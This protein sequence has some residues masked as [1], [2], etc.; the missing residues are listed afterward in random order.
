MRTV[1]EKAGFKTEMT[2]PE[3]SM[4]DALASAVKGTD[5]EEMSP[6]EAI[7]AALGRITSGAT[8]EDDSAERAILSQGRP[9]AR[10]FRFADPK[11][12]ADWADLRQRGRIAGHVK[13][14]S[15]HNTGEGA[16]FSQVV[17]WLEFDV[18][19]EKMRAEAEIDTARMLD[20]LRPA[21]EPAPKTVKRAKGRP[22]KKAVKLAEVD[23]PPSTHRS[24]E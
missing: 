11:D 2:V 18:P 15:F 22:P 9:N 24:I 14:M 6:E 10:L 5:M 16:D 23:K 1:V 17:E 4:A 3:S 20:E 12:A 13:I 7:A 19:I 8:S 21:H